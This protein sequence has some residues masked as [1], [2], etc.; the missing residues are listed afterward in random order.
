MTIQGI[1]IGLGCVVV[2]SSAA[3]VKKFP[4]YVEKCHQ[5]D[6]EFST[7]ILKA[8]QLVKPHLKTGIPE[9][10]LPKMDPLVLP[11]VGIDAGAGFI[12]KFENVEIYDADKFVIRR[13]DINLDQNKIKFDLTFPHIRIKAHYSIF[14][15]VLFFNLDGSGPADGNITDCRVIATVN[16]ERYFNQDKQHMKL[17]EI[18]IEDMN[19]GNPNFHFYE[20]FRNNPELTEQTNRIL[21]ANMEEL[22]NDLRPTVEQTIGK[23]VLEFIGRVFARFS[24]EELFPK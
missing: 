16:G 4:S 8:I 9:F 3:R 13:F 19:F 20:L 5:S 14:G 12:A 2:L 18:V 11:E 15:K 7:C 17:S 24:I 6:V 1:L 23:T 10:R 21:N 22:L